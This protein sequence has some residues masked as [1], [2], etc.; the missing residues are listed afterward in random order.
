MRLAVA[1]RGHLL[2]RHSLA[3][4]GRS[5]GVGD[6]GTILHNYR[7]KRRADLT[8][9]YLLWEAYK[10][11]AR[12]DNDMNR[13]IFNKLMPEFPQPERR[14]MDRV[15]RCAMVPKF[16]VDT[17]MLEQHLLD[18]RKE[19]AQL[20]T[21]AGITEAGELRSTAK[22]QN[23]L[24]Q[25]GVEIVRKPSVTDPSRT[26]PAF[27]KTDQF[28]ADLLQHEDPTVQA[29]AAARLGVRSTIEETRTV[30]LLSIAKLDWPGYCDGNLPVPLKY[31]GA[32]THRLSG[33]WSCNLQNLPS[34]RG[35]KV[36]KLRKAL[37][38]PPGH[39]VVVADKSQVEC[40]AEG[41]LV[42]TEQGPKAIQNVQLTDRVWDGTEFVS[43]EGVVF[44]GIQTVISYQGLTA[45]P[46]HV[47]YPA[48]DPAKEGV[49][50]SI[51]ATLGLD[52]QTA[53]RAHAVRQT[54][55]RSSVMSRLQDL[56][57]TGHKISVQG[58]ENLSAMGAGKLVAPFLRWAGDRPHRQRRTLR[59]GQFA[60]VNT[61][62][63]CQQ[64]DYY[65]LGDDAFR[66]Q[67]GAGGFQA[68]IPGV[69]LWSRSNPASGQART[70]RR[71]DNSALQ[72]Q[73]PKKA[74]VYDIVNAGPRHR[75][76]VS[77]VIVSN[78]RITAYICGQEDL[79]QLFRDRADP[80]AAMASRIF[81]FEV[82]KT[83]HPVHRF[84]GKSATLGL[85]YGCGHERFN[86][87]VISSARMLGVDLGTT[88][89][90]GMARHAVKV[91]RL[92]NPRIVF[93]WKRLDGILAT[94]WCHGV[95][96]VMQFG[97][98][99]IGHGYVEGPGDLKMHY[100]KPRFD[101]ETQEFLFDY[102]G[103]THKMY[104]A[105]MLE[106]I[107]QFL[108]RTNTM[109]DALRIS[110]RGYPFQMQSHDELIWIV[111]DDKVDDCLETALREMRRAPMWAPGLPLDAE[112][113]FG[114]SYGDVK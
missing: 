18:I 61:A 103:R 32:H 36:S 113:G 93:A 8:G 42:L 67:I 59:T 108:A 17:P 1:L 51:A 87:M 7:G 96:P 112:G 92:A 12:N 44:K 28:M 83:K 94:T 58:R 47:V 100:G 80:Y 62:G 34:G 79:L 72:D 60:T 38:A 43:H 10:S 5:L 111:P 73:L 69:R 76:M 78:C 41:Q 81:G 11:Y 75:F 88:W 110:D 105:K 85:G 90:E 37:C 106:N 52:I 91:Y 65:G 114:Q 46:E 19:R 3:E 70:D 15:M 27:S 33:D 50:L 40:I 31:A 89:D 86:A 45:T 95:P 35:G 68:A 39:K 53:N 97:P 107:V 30:R 16:K 14:I 71:T 57:R 20:L 102:A 24:V 109:H 13:N 21:S 23:L 22:F 49:P 84:I 99:N 101:A 63:E 6:K 74:K 64:P 104:G 56:W 82:D 54:Q 9:N 48:S 25:R 2:Q 29:L 77:G 66:H 98:V 55:V 4:V 26:I